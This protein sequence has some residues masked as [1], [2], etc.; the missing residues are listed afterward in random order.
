MTHP[1]RQQRLTDSRCFWAQIIL[2]TETT[3]SSASTAVFSAL[4][5]T[6]A[7]HGR[8]FFNLYPNVPS[9]RP[10]LDLVTIKQQCVSYSISTTLANIASCGTLPARN[11]ASHGIWKSSSTQIGLTTLIAAAHEAAM[12]SAPMVTHWPTEPASNQNVLHPLRWQNT[13]PLPLQSKR[14]STSNNF[15]PASPFQLQPRS[16]SMKTT[17]PA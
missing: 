16:K 3:C 8:T 1:C 11:L 13:S 9:S 10:T 15:L 7:T 6:V 5:N 4:F 2:L 12:S 14:S 17:A